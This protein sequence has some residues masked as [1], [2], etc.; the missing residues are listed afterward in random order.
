MISIITIVKNDRRI[1]ILLEKLIEIPK[2]EKVEIIVVDNSEGNLDDIK[3]FFPSIRWIYY[4][5]KANKKYTYSEQRNLGL[6]KAE[7]EIIVFIDSDCIP[8]KSWLIEL[9]KPIRGEGENIV[10]GIIK[11]IGK[12]STNNI[13]WE[14]I[15]NKKYLS[16]GLTGNISFNKQILKQV[17]YF[18]EDFNGG[19][20]DIDFSWRAV[21]LGYRINYNKDAV[22]YH[23]WGN[24]KREIERALQCGKVSV[25]LYK[26]HPEKWKKLFSSN[27]DVLI[28]PLYILFFPITFLWPYYL[29]F[30]LIPISRN[31]FTKSLRKLAVEKVFLDLVRGWG[32][33]TELFY[34]NR[35][36]EK[37]ENKI[38]K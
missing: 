9:V 14:K 37:Y 28:Y 10:V 23:D 25:R 30:L 7:G 5:N 21:N 13:I 4:S 20:E 38:I 3:G 29:L 8:T 17:G 2:P 1:K 26:K 12:S 6:K 32:V 36:T 11:S 22:V 31:L 15:R 24:L 16:E 18:S 35:I 33:L 27:A 19:G 34:L